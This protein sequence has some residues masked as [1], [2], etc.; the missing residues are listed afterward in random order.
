MNKTI[1]K[2]NTFPKVNF[3]GNKENIANWICEY[4][5][6]DATS[7]F[8]VFSGGGSVSYFSKKKGVKVISN[9]ILTINYLIAKSLIE[10]NGEHLSEK[11]VSIIFSGKPMK[12]FMYNNYAN[13]YYFPEECMELDLYRKN[14]EKLS[15]LY[16]KATAL[17]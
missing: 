15:S 6:K 1:S 11:D 13:K 16:K 9:D 12:G 2:K 10:N 17:I 14:I 5:P 8:D 3:I 7:V 4:F